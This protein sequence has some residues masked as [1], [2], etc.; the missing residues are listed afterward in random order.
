MLRQVSGML[1]MLAMVVG[2]ALGDDIKG[3]VKST[4]VEK[5]TITITVNDK[6]QTLNV[7]KDA[8][9][10]GLYGKKLNKA[11]IRDI[12]GGLSGVRAGANVTVTTEKKDDKEFA[13]GVK[14][15]DLQKKKKGT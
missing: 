2:V 13:I 15:E 5:N 7:S 4:D 14:V 8:K 10:V 12:P 9:F 11:Q 1:V 6:D 3:R